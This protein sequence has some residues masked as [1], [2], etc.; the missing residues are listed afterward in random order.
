MDSKNAMNN[1]SSLSH[2]PNQNDGTESGCEKCAGA[3]NIG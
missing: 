3:D 1:V 2:G